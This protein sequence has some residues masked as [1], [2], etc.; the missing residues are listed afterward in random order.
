MH[1]NMNMPAANDK[2]LPGQNCPPNPITAYLVAS[3]NNQVIGTPNNINANRYCLAHSHNKG[4]FTWAHTA[5][6]PIKNKLNDMNM[7]L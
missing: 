3:I 6:C 1:V 7:Y 2:N 4:P 5:I